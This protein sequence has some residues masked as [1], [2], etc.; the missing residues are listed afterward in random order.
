MKL[1]MIH[2]IEATTLK[3]KEM[4]VKGFFLGDGTSGVYKYNSGLKNCW[5]LNNLDFRIIEK[6]CEI[7]NNMLMKLGMRTLKF[8]TLENQVM[9]IE[10]LQ[11][12]RR[13][14]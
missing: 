6:L 9:F 10:L 2:N 8:M 13:W 7:Q 3:E 5:T 14:H 4:F 1:L 11:G 12:R